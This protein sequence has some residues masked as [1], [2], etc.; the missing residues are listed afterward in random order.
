MNSFEDKPIVILGVNHSGTRALVDVLSLLGSDAGDNDTKWKESKTFIKAHYQLL[1][2]RTDE[3][4]NNTIFDLRLYGGDRLKYDAGE[5]T[6]F[7]AAQLPLH[8]PN[9]MNAPWHWKCPSS[10][11]FL[12]FWVNLYP[13]GFYLHIVRDKYDVAYSL[14]RRKQFRSLRKALKF[15][16][17][18]EQKLAMI[19]RYPVRYLKV[20]YHRLEEELPRIMRFLSFLDGDVTKAR[21]LIHRE[22]SK[23]GWRGDM[24]IKTN[25]WNNFNLMKLK[26]ARKLSI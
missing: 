16:E 19:T 3:E 24:P 11:L 7:L 21:Q 12:D 23:L 15:H 6:R 17:L 8:F 1:G 10:A 13:H 2:C 9:R 14:L 18:F 4:W 26:M 20:D 5:V 22:K 25:L